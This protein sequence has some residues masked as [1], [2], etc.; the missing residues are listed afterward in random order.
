MKKSMKWFVTALLLVAAAVVIAAVFAPAKH[1]DADQRH[2]EA[3]ASPA[4][5]SDHNGLAVINLD[6]Q[7]QRR[8]NIRIVR[9]K[10]T[11]MRTEL[12]ATAVVL[13][14]GGL[15]ATRNNY[16][17]AARTKLERDQAHLI[18]LHS[19]YQRV[20][21]L[22]EENQNMSLKAMQDA[23]TAYGDSKAQLAIDKQDA[24]LQLD[25]VRQS[26]GSVVTDWIA[27]N[28]PILEAILQQQDFLVQ[29]VFP[30]GE[31]ATPP[32]TLYLHLPSG[33][34]VASRFVSPFPQVNLEIQGISF[35]YL[36]PARPG[37][38]IGMNLVVSVPVGQSLHGTL[39]P[40]DAVVW[41]HANAWVYEETS[42]STFTRR[43][44]PTGNPLPDGYFVSG[45]TFAPGAKIVTSGAQA[46][47]SEEL[48]LSGQGGAEGDT[49]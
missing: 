6:L 4:H 48:I 16:V 12:S 27:Q 38:A 29:V 15:A 37:L 8:A 46:L 23:E 45:D 44:V 25:V 32:R 14:V 9:L 40:G 30:P 3:V 19:Q 43:M 42:P 33:H 21:Q 13:A 7:G 49:D 17:A 2:K 20:K 5:L 34:F 36:V 22:Y 28:K 11:S 39:I 10:P 31:V 1:S 24:G 47:L 26:W 18:V 41:S 35:L